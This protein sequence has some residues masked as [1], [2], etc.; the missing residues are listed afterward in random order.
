MAKE[1]LG[2]IGK[3]AGKDSAIISYNGLPLN[4]AGKQLKQKVK[5]TASKAEHERVIKGA[6]QTQLKDLLDNPD[7]YGDF[8]R[9]IGVIA[10]GF[11]DAAE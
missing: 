2:L 4:L 3:H 6:T 5:A 10:G 1:K 9:I 8:S 11:D 7:K